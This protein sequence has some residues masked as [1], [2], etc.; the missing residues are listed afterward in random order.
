MTC[1]ISG[2][3]SLKHPLRLETVLNN[4]W[5]EPGSTIWLR[6]GIYD[7]AQ[8][9]PLFMGTAEAPITIRSYPGETAIIEGGIED[10]SEN[11]IWRD[12]FFRYYDWSSRLSASED[13]PPPDIYYPQ[14]EFNGENTSV[15]NC[16]FDNVYHVGWWRFC[17]PGIYYGNISL[18]PGYVTPT[19]AHGPGIYAQNVG[20]LRYIKHNVFCYSARLNVHIYSGTDA[21]SN[22]VTVENTMWGHRDLGDPEQRCESNEPSDNLQ[23]IGNCAY[24]ETTTGLSIGDDSNIVTN[25]VL[26]NNISPSGIYR[27]AFVTFTTDEGNIEEP[28]TGTATRL[29]QN[30]YEST[31]ALLTIFNWDADDYVTVDVSDVYAPGSIIQAWS[32][33]AGLNS[34]AVK[35]DTTLLVVDGDGNITIDMRAASHS[36]LTP[37]GPDAW[38]T[39]KTFP[40]F[41]C[42]QLD[43]V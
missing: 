34:S 24:H 1:I 17:S 30:E 19:S 43:Q 4:Q 28:G 15:I 8:Y 31:R 32:I 7:T 37:V 42:F 38:E 5:I 18:A 41:A 12:L 2:L 36:V 35:Q 11:V 25:A 22:M 10:N 23:L 20:T 26:Q 29:W 9:N 14:I 16:I 13:R 3:G 21:L 39:T 40:E 27:G 33:Q 6:G